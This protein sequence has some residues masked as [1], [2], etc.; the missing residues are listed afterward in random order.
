MTRHSSKSKFVGKGWSPSPQNGALV[1]V[2]SSSAS[3]LLFPSLPSFSFSLLPDSDSGSLS[4]VAGPSLTGRSARAAGREKVPS[5]YPRDTYSIDVCTVVQPCAH[6]CVHIP[7]TLRYAGTT[8]H[9]GRGRSWVQG[10]T[11]W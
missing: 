9:P 5:S 8:N 11:F 6:T 4:A 3:L 2:L 7:V 1:H 10:E